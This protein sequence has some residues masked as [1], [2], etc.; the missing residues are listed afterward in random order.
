M[1]R[2]AKYSIGLEAEIFFYFDTEGRVINWSFGLGETNIK[3]LFNL[4]TKEVFTDIADIV[5]EVGK[6]PYEKVLSYLNT[7]GLTEVFL[8]YGEEPF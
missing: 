8:P 6:K 5:M 4:E 2:Q 3:D 1:T 7:L